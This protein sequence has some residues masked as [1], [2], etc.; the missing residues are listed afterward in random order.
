MERDRG[1]AGVRNAYRE[2]ITPYLDSNLPSA[3]AD[4]QE[5]SSSRSRPHTLAAIIEESDEE[6]LQDKSTGHDGGDSPTIPTRLRDFSTAFSGTGDV[7]PSMVFDGRIQPKQSF[8]CQF[9]PA[10][11]PVAK[12]RH[13]QWLVDRPNFRTFAQVWSI[14]SCPPAGIEH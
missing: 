8:S 2:V 7:A 11:F 1:K 4:D 12:F 6:S 3:S 14:R 9:S 10:H 13:F 5:P